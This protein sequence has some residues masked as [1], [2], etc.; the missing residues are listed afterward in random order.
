MNNYSGRLAVTQY[1]DLFGLVGAARD[2]EKETRDFYAVDLQRVGNETALSAKTTFYNVL[3]AQ[4][5]VDVQQEQVN[6]AAENLRIATARYN[7]GAAAQFDVVTAQT[8]L[9]NAQQLLISDRNNLDLTRANLNNL[10]GV[11]QD[12]P[13]ALQAPPLPPI[14]QTFDTAQSLQTAFTRRPELVQ[15]QSNINIARRL[16]KL[17]GGTLTPTFGIV[18]SAGYAGA[19]VSGTPRDTYSLSAVLGIPLS[20]GGATRSRVRSAQVDLDTQTVTQAQLKESVELEVRQALINVTD[21]Q[22]RAAA[23]QQGVTQ[24]AEAVRLA[25]V[26]YQ[27]GLGTFLDVTNAQANLATARTNLLG[28]QF[29]YQTALAQLTRAEGGR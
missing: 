29:D 23:A 7:A 16:I 12:V 25:Q 19:T 9:S 26:R 17:A 13:L 14:T 18:G 15:A 3:R 6:Y 8:N 10:L 5:Q 11:R 20:D 28:A 1:V 24:A 22:A 21:A 27:N 4:S 2:V